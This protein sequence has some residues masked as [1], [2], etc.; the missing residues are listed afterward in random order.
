MERQEDSVKIMAKWLDAA[1]KRLNE[2]ELKEFCYGIIVYGLY[3]GEIDCSDKVGMA[4]EMVYPQIDDMQGAYNKILEN[5]KLGADEV[6][7]ARDEE[8]WDL[9][10]NKGLKIPEIKRAL[11]EKYG[12]N[13]SQSTLYHC[14]GWE[15]RKLDHPS[16]L[17]ESSN[18]NEEIAIL[19]KDLQNQAELPKVDETANLQKEENLA[20]NFAKWQF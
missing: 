9:A 6:R 10:H 14:K 2:E 3:K 15:Q 4:L 1:Q 13:I 12:G 17:D 20:E 18:K 8:V 7:K 5:A 11:D 19:Q 16:F